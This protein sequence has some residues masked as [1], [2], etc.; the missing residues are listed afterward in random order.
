MRNGSFGFFALAAG[1]FALV[2]E[3]PNADGALLVIDPQRQAPVGGNADLAGPIVAAEHA[4]HLGLVDVPKPHQAVVA[5]RDRLRTVRNDRH[6][7]HRAGMLEDQRQRFFAGG[8]I[9]LADGAIGA[10]G[11]HAAAV[12]GEFGGGDLAGV[13][14]ERADFARPVC[15]FH[16]VQ[17]PCASPTK[18]CLSSGEKATAVT[19]AAQRLGRAEQFAG[20]GVPKPGGHVRRCR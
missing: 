3:I 7:G 16:S 1:D 13:R 17:W 15:E 5:E 4:E 12:G 10:G 18:N 19:S 20:F 6:G 14:V 2:V 8:D 11:E 9:P